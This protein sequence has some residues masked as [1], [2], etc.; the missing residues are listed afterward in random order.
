MEIYSIIIYIF[1][2]DSRGGQGKALVVI[3]SL[4]R[5]KYCPYLAVLFLLLVLVAQ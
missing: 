1:E 4:P 5:L 2:R 3:N